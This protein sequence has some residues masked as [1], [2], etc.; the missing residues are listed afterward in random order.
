MT[1]CT[2]WSYR[3]GDVALSGEIYRPANSANGQAVLVVQEADGIGGNV[4]R[5]SRMLADLG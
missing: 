5:H 1:S 4:R 3:D 2:Q